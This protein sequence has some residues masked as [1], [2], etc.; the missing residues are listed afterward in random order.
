M[1]LD[2]LLLFVLL[3]TWGA[4]VTVPRRLAA[5]AR[6][7]SSRHAPDQDTAPAASPAPARAPAEAAAVQP[8]AGRLWRLTG[9]PLA[10]AG[11]VAGLVLADRNPDAAIAAHLVPLLASTPGRLLAV[12]APALLAGSLIASLAGGRLEDAG[13]RIAAALALA[14]CAAASWA[15]ELL[16]AGDGPS[17]PPAGLVLLVVC[18]LALTLAA[19]ELLA[20]GRAR[21][22]APGAVALLAYLALLPSELRGVLSSQGLPLTCGAAALLLMAARWL[23]GALRR[24]AL[25][26]GLLLAAIV[27]AQAGHVSQ[28]LAPAI[29][30]Q[31]ESLLR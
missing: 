2:A 28:A 18:R 30:I 27:L 16:R 10:I 3:V 29:E 9:S 14:A 24:L 23:P 5:S 15:G 19:G 22:A 31:Y 6:A 17:S 11:L 7:A 12:L 26:P 20:P 25:A 4:Q 21:W 8:A 13:Q 1:L